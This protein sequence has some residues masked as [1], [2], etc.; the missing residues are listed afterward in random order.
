MNRLKHPILHEPRSRRETVEKER[1]FIAYEEDEEEIGTVDTGV[2][3]HLSARI[4][5]DI[6]ADMRVA[7]SGRAEIIITIR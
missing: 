2:D 5:D 3:E 1:I 6:V 7:F 4:L